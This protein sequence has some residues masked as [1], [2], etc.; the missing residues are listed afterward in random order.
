METNAERV[1][2]AE[3]A[4]RL[5]LA[6]STVKRYLD[7]YP[8]LKGDDGLIDYREL[9]KHRGDNPRTNEAPDVTPRKPAAPPKQ[10]GRSAAKQRLEEASAEIREIE[11]AKMRGELVDAGLIGDAVTEAAMMLRD[12]LTMP[13]L[14]TCEKFAAEQNPRA[15]QAMFREYH[16]GALEALV[17]D[18]DK[19]KP[20][21]T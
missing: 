19:A 3:A 21:K 5:N 6:R 11:L 13:D 8:E 7:E 1:K 12:K 17:A 14:V 15:I 10:T 9:A 18:L 2:P 4:R 20:D 16:R